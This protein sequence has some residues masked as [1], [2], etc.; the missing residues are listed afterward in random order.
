MEDINTA[1]ANVESKG[2]FDVE[3]DPTLDLFGEIEKLKKEKMR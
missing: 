2:F 3:V 1:L